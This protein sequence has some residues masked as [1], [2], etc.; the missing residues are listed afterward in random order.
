VAKTSRRNFLVGGL[1]GAG[2][3]SLGL[4]AYAKNGRELPGATIPE[5]MGPLQPVLDETSGLPILCLPE[6]FRY[7]TLSWAGTELHDGN[8]VPASADGMGVV[9]QVGSRVTL[10]RNHELQGSSGAIGLPENAYDPRTPGGTTTLVFDAV[11][12]DVVDSRISL[13]GTLYNCAGGVTPWGTWLSCEEAA[14]SPRL[15]HMAPIGKHVWWDIETAEK[16]HGFVFEVPAEGVA[17]PVP[18]VE[19]GQFEHEAVAIDPI[20]GVAYMTEDMVPSAGFYRF[21]PDT[22]GR[23]G[24]GGRLQ[25]MKVLN[26]PDMTDNLVLGQELDTEWVDI[27]D[28]AQGFIPGTRKG[29]GV[30]AQGLAAGA[31]RFVALEGCTFSQGRVYLTSKLGGRFSAGYVLEYDPQRE[32]IWMVFE[33][34]GHDHFS[35]PDNIV[36]SPRGSLVICEDRL[37][38]RKDAQSIAGLSKEGQFFRFCRVNPD[39]S[40]QFAGHKLRQTALGSEW[41]GVTFSQDGQWLFAN[42]YSPG[43]TVAITGPWQ[44]GFI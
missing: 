19:M 41:A 36:V 44:E 5:L 18:I 20:S 12:E 1:A 27:P 22:P 32:K 26:R 37:H 28:P 3:V 21:M 11:S 16:E 2:A 30:S 14:F 42:I 15:T 13:G 17:K 23:L 31:S 43:V 29:S 6:G 4:I 24:Q 40:G 7:K 9:R 25:M 33:S 10:V 39:L 38:D 34:E 8:R 35:G